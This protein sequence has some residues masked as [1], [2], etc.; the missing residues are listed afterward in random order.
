MG[1]YSEQYNLR[2]EA[3]GTKEVL[4][5]LKAIDQMAERLEKDGLDIRVNVNGLAQAQSQVRSLS[6]QAEQLERD[7]IDLKVNV[8]G[9]AQAMGEINGITAAQARAIRA[10][11]NEAKTQVGVERQKIGVLNDQFRLY[12]NLQKSSSGLT[13]KIQASL[14][15]MNQFSNSVA[16]AASTVQ[17]M[18][19]MLAI[20]TGVGIGAI[21][22]GI[23]GQVKGAFKYAQEVDKARQQLKAQGVE[24]KKLEGVY[25]DIVK[26]ANVSPFDV[27]NMTQA[28]SQMNSFTGDIDK[29]MRATK[30]FSESIFAS[31]GD[32]SALGNVAYNLGQISTNQFSK[33]D[34]K[35]LV[36]NVPAMSQALRQ[37]KGDITLVDKATGKLVKKSTDG[38]NLSNWED[39]NKLLGDDPT[40]QAIERQYDAFSLVTDA[41]EK[42]NQQTHALE[43]ANKALPNKLENLAGAYKT[44]RHEALES[45]GAYDAFGKVIDTL[46]NKL[47]KDPAV[48][49]ALKDLFS[50]ITPLI[51]K[52]EQGIKNFD[53]TAFVNGLKEG[54]RMIADNFKAIINNPIIQGFGKMLGKAIGAEGNVGDIGRGLGKLFNLGVD[55]FLSSTAIKIAFTGLSKGSALVNAG[56]HASKALGNMLGKAKIPASFAT[57]AGELLGTNVGQQFKTPAF[58]S[59]F[60]GK[61][62]AF[63]KGG[64]QIGGGVAAAGIGIGIGAWAGAQ[65]MKAIV[66]VAKKLTDTVN[67]V[68]DNLP[69]ANSDKAYQMVA[70]LHLLDKMAAIVSNAG[71]GGGMKSTISSA[72]TNV[73]AIASGFGMATGNLTLAGVGLM[74]QGVRLLGAYIDQIS[75]QTEGIK[76]ENVAKLAALPKKFDAIPA[77]F[78]PNTIADKIKKIQDT[79]SKVHEALGIKVADNG[80]VAMSS[81]GEMLAQIDQAIP[82]NT[83]ARVTKTFTNLKTLAQTF[84]SFGDI[85]ETGSQVVTGLN[86]LRSTISQLVNS[87]IFTDTMG[88][89]TINLPSAGGSLIGPHQVQTDTT[90]GNQLGQLEA[91]LSTVTGKIKSMLPKIKLLSDLS[92][93]LTAIPPINPGAIAQKMTDINTT[94]TSITKIWSGAE[95]IA[96]DGKSGGGSIGTVDFSAILEVIR[97]GIKVGKEVA[98][99]GTMNIPNAT[100]QINNMKASIEALGGLNGGAGLGGLND[101]LSQ[102]G[103]KI[104][105]FAGKANGTGVTSSNNLK[106]AL[107]QLGAASTSNGGKLTDLGGKA[108]DAGSKFD[109]TK[110]KADSLKSAIDNVGSAASGAGGKISSLASQMNAI[111]S[112]AGNAKGALDSLKGAIDSLPS[113]KSIKITVNDEASSSISTIQSKLNGIQSKSVDVT[114]NYKETGKKGKSATGGVMMAR[115]GYVSQLFKNASR[116]FG[117]GQDTI[118]AVLARGEAV[119]RRSST[120]ILGKTFVDHVNNGRMQQ[121]YETMGNRMSSMYNNR[122]DNRSFNN[123]ANITQNFYGGS[124]DGNNYLKSYIKGV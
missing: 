91:Q 1:A 25:Q 109:S 85:K 74:V 55:G 122:Y 24:G 34:Y 67:Y 64:L 108:N 6:A 65:G 115:G 28:V 106:N 20:G 66:E 103:A 31:G 57:E 53:I 78:D 52:A 100:G 8:N 110:G 107:N 114:T 88:T 2:L 111:V 123:Q 11:Q 104:T 119:I 37:Y 117:A 38:L 87:G 56:I 19:G 15:G 13:D 121:A 63:L 92:A 118:N 60:S 16:S 58:S 47:Q 39:F 10:N 69:N 98:T 36:K 101:M 32:I 7:G 17:R 21:G 68:A 9:Y 81:V 112:A 46:S 49:G 95:S 116:T 43:T 48:K 12:N 73:A 86:N 97:G 4:A 93:Q 35:E 89:K 124:S 76:I 72:I 113:S 75:A 41:M 80:Y 96:G 14:R 50:G 42:Y 102:A 94:V 54:G 84:Q 70:K 77:D 23:A 40:T 82:A 99:L 33:V 26:Y 51:Q 29:S 45:S 59:A 61:L 5:E 120:A 71:L 30:A 62:G 3:V 18:S 105:E 90:M 22:V 83:T 27:G 79:V 44:V